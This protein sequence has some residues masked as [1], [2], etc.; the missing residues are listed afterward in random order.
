MRYLPLLLLCLATAV[1]AQSPAPQPAPTP[2]P[3]PAA[4]LPPAPR[5]EVASTILMDYTTGQVLAAQEPDARVEPASITKVM[6]AY[7]FFREIEAGRLKLDEEVRVSENAWQRGLGGSRMFVKAG[8]LV[9]VEELLLGLIVQSG[10]DATIALAEHVAGSE[11]AFVAMMNA[12]AQRLGLKGTNF[13]NSPGLP[14]P[15]HYSTARDIA[16]LARAMIRDFPQYYAWYSIREYTY[17]GIRQYNRNALLGR[18]E[19]VDGIKTGHTS[20]AGYCLVSSAKRGD[21][22]LI[23]VVMGSK[24][25]ETRAQQSQAL[26]NYGFRFFE[27]HRLYPA[28]QALAALRLWKGESE[29]A[30]VGLQHALDLVVPRSSYERLEARMDLPKY[31]IAPLPKGQVIGQLKV[32]LDGELLAER[33]LV[34]LQDASESG[35]FSRAYDGFWL[36]F[37][38]DA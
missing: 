33:P 14:G 29:Q 31:L 28:E 19:S 35:W 37:E 7:T 13:S 20:A 10:N 24:S 17:N 23:A 22:R 36:W 32:L 27:T 4:P 3:A 21:A 8:T 30:E 26:L 11:E 18:D 9:T 6:A 16:E 1:S 12:E 5:F 34:L 38:D 15:D 2:A 25:E